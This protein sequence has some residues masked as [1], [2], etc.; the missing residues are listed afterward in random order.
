M[1]SARMHREAH[2]LAALQH[3]N[4]INIFDYSGKDALKP[5]LVMERLRGKPLDVLLEK[6]PID[7]SLAAHLGVQIGGALAHAH[8]QGLVHRDVKPANV[9]LEPGGRLVLID[10]GIV[11]G[12][13]A[14]SHTFGGGQSTAL[15]GTPMFASP[16]Q[17]FGD[18]EITAASDVFSLGAMLYFAVSGTHPYPAKRID[19]LLSA[20]RK[21]NA[22]PLG[23]VANVP[24]AFERAV[25]KAL[26][27]EP[28][29]RHAS[30]DAFARALAAT[31]TESAE[32]AKH[33]F[34]S[35]L[36]GILP[37]VGSTAP[38]REISRTIEVEPSASWLRPVAVASVLIA[39]SAALWWRAFSG[40]RS[41][42]PAVVISAPVQVQQPAP[43]LTLPA[44]RTDIVVEVSVVPWGKVTIDGQ[45]RGITPS[46]RKATLSAGIHEI[47]ASNPGLG[48]KKIQIDLTG[49]VSPYEL[50]IDL[51]K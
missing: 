51:E 40:K 6:G 34:A 30:A 13:T 1:L 42:R 7:A 12:T 37:A 50:V 5:Y 22:T 36:E 21:G 47:I 10:F 28:R 49:K 14:S 11:K 32:D 38:V 25:M 4:I 46:F 16:E 19:Q 39:L 33:R 35:W 23:T 27:P 31:T 26:A 18:N 17:L 45:M 3:P 20:L 48:E 29:Q 44:P 2:S 41:V 24:P 9:H 8:L 43:D 15:V